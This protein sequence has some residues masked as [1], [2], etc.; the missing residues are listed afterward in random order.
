M[1]RKMG[2]L[3][4]FI[5]FVTIVGYGFVKVSSTLPKIIKDKSPIKVYYTAKPFDVTIDMGD[6][7]F[8][9]NNKVFKNIRNFIEEL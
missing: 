5:F 2:H 3:M 6:Y 4:V 8:Y 7:I 1:L 9:V